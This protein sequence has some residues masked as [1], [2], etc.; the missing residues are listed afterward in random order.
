MKSLII[1]SLA[2]TLLI[3]GPNKGTIELLPMLVVFAKRAS[4]SYSFNITTTGALRHSSFRILIMTFICE[5][6]LVEIL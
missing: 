3:F 4:L 1:L 5:A 6:E 2:Y